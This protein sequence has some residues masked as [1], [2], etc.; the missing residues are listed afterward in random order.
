MSTTIRN[1]GGPGG[2][3]SMWRLDEDGYVRRAEV[4][5][6]EYVTLPDTA[7]YILQIHGVSDLFPMPSFETRN[8]PPDEQKMEL[9]I[10][11]EFLIHKSKS[12]GTKFNGRLYSEIFT[13]YVSAGA[14]L[15]KVLRA[16]QGGE[17]IEPDAMVE[18]T[19]WLGRFIGAP[20]APNQSGKRGKL[21][22]PSPVDI[23]KH[24][25]ALPDNLGKHP[26]DVDEEEADWAD[27]ADLVA[28]GAATKA[29]W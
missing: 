4:N 21:G 20:I 15:G 27:E 6:D 23:R 11:L 29:P 16:A 7:D 2:N 3:G 19:D 24:N 10:R 18:V 17:D 9:Q 8:L 26:D 14:R 28:S 5:R 13:P 1:T 12:G 22:T 25:L